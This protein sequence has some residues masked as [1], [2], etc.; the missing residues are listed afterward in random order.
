MTDETIKI[1]SQRNH[2]T[3]PVYDFLEDK[4]P[5]VESLNLER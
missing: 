2:L 1:L 3:Y 5:D 4:D